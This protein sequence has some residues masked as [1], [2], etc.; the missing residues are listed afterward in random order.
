MKHDLIVFNAIPE[1][2]LSV[3][4]CQAEKKLKAQ[5]A[6][7]VQQHSKTQEVLKEKEKDSEKLQVQLKTAQGSFEEEMKKLR[8]K[9]AELQEVNV[10][11]VSSIPNSSNEHAFFSQRGHIYND[12]HL[13]TSHVYEHVYEFKFDSHFQAEDE[14]KLREQVSGLGQKLDSEKSQTAELQKTLEQSQQSFTKLQ[15]DFYG[16]ES[17]VS[18]LRQDLKVGSCQEELL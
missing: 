3:Y 15:S 17:E 10:K 18:A 1:Q 16:K 7:L 9:V 13:K 12:N 2:M 14:S 6:S 4:K 11:K 5:L 8:G